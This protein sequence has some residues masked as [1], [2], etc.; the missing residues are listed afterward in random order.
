MSTRL[1]PVATAFLQKVP[2]PNLPGEVQNYLASPTLRNDNHQGVGRLDQHLTAKDTLFGRVYIADFD[3][4]QPF[5][6]SLLNESLVPGFGYYLTTRT[7]SVTVGETHVFRHNVISESRFGFLGVSG[8][9]Q[10]QN[11]GIDFAAQ[12]GIGGIAPAA[13][14]AGYPSVSFSGAYSTVGDPANLFTRQNYSV[15]LMENLSWIKGSHSMKFGAY[16][17]R[18]HFNP[19]ESPNARGSFTFTPRYTSSAAG[20]GDGNSFT[21][22]L[23]GYPS[24]AQAGIG[25]GGSENGRSTWTHFYAQD[26]W[27]IRRSLTVNYGLRYEINGKITDTSNRLSSIELD[28]F[29]IASDDEGRINPLANG[30]LDL[31]PVP[32]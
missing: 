11:Q 21:D 25:P 3:T 18:L 24:S 29:V 32:T 31:I 13:D 4:F 2:L 23:L 10:S 17:F 22:F 28:R 14:Q 7:K 20:L 15:D 12:N 26:D 6:S 27:R 5:G 16:I 19:S 1:D 8:G 9:Q 30:M